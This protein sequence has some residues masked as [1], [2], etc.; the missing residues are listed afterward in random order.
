MHPVESR[1]GREPTMLGVVTLTVVSQQ[2]QWL[3]T[4]IVQQQYLALVVINPFS[5]TSVTRKTNKGE[6]RASHDAKKR[7][8]AEMPTSFFVAEF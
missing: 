5:V 4:T 2:R 1:C 3:H 7:G 8:L 6:Y